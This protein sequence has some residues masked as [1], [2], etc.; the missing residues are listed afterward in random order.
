MFSGKKKSFDV[1]EFP[2]ELANVI[3]DG[4]KHGVSDE[5]MAKG[6]VS[7]GN[8]MGQFV[9]PDSPE[10]ALMKEMWEVASDNEK[11]TVANLVLRIGK[12]KLGANN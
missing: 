6:M 2:K 9:K 1:S 10:E 5:M 3:V 12:E 7:I 4:Q 11:M 8:P